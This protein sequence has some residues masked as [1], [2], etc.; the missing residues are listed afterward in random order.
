MQLQDLRAG[1]DE[2][3]VFRVSDDIA[4]TTAPAVYSRAYLFQTSSQ[5]RAIFATCLYLLNAATNSCISTRIAAK[6][7]FHQQSGSLW[8]EYRGST[9]YTVVHRHRADIDEVKKD[10]GTLSEQE[11]AHFK[12]WPFVS[13][14]CAGGSSQDP[15]EE[16]LWSD[17]K[18]ILEAH[19]QTLSEQQGE[20]LQPFSVTPC[21]LGLI[22]SMESLSKPEIQLLEWLATEVRGLNRLGNMIAG[23]SKTLTTDLHLPRF[24][25]A[26]V[27]ALQQDVYLLMTS[28]QCL[29]ALAIRNEVIA[30]TTCRILDSLVEAP[31]AIQTLAFDPAAAATAGSN[32]TLQAAVKATV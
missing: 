25:T 16:A 12:F 2:E 4:G 21:V 31:V 11:G 8:L 13:Y 23:G 3:S 9:E 32:A 10:L 5:V 7:Q 30:H 24:E 22:G 1:F 27:P 17:I 20:P 15:E 28:Q 18:E 19:N 29:T 14:V 6:E 26:P